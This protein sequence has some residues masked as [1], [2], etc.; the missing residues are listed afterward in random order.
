MSKVIDLNNE[1]MS[2]VKTKMLK[3]ILT[4]SLR[5]EFAPN[6]SGNIHVELLGGS[7]ESVR[8]SLNNIPYPSEM[9]GVLKALCNTIDTK[10]DSY[11][12]KKQYKLYA[13]EADED[14]N[15]E[16]DVDEIF[17]DAE[18]ETEK[19]DDPDVDTESFDSSTSASDSLS[20]AIKSMFSDLANKQAEEIK[21]LAKTVLKLEKIKQDD[22]LKEKKEESGEF[23]EEGIEEDTEDKNE[24]TSDTND[25]EGEEDSGDEENPF[26]SNDDDDSNDDS[27][28]P[29]TSEGGD[30]NSNEDEGE[31]DNPFGSD[32]GDS[33]TE[34]DNPFDDGEEKNEGEAS[35]ENCREYSEIESRI[36]GTPNKVNL[37][38]NLRKGDVLNYAKYITK[39]HME[40]E[41][42]TAYS[43]E[44]Q[45]ELDKSMNKYKK[46]TKALIISMADTLSV[47]HSIGIPMNIDYVKYPHLYHEK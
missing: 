37:L 22:E 5:T 28:N 42:S 14:S 31:G 13:T 4:K 34:S 9:Q 35:F 7:F 19:G 6:Y 30:T 29:F 40:K 45:E 43:S 44:S 33:N 16:E 41:L 24:D 8:D 32:E 47:G 18:F 2:K 11:A 38:N 1:K 15:D 46:L 20:D 17:K 25:N 27:D 21:N 23:T 12:S 10:L 36:L 39:R 3:T 26:G